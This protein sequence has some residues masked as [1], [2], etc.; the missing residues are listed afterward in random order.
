LKKKDYKG[1]RL[2]VVTASLVFRALYISLLFTNTR[3]FVAV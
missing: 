2:A 3:L 1:K